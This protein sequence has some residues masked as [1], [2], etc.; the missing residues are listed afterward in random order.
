VKDPVFV[1]HGVANRNRDEFSTA[2]SALA[3][4]AGV[5]MVPVHW[6]D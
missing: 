5:E 2:V 1:I 6:G 4:A 3:V